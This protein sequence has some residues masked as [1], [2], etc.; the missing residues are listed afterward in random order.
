MKPEDKIGLDSRCN[1]KQVEIF[2]HNLPER[3]TESLNISFHI[4]PATWGTLY[5]SI[6][7]D[8]PKT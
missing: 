5:I 2:D 8:F 1:N 4:D 3:G 6:R 7:A